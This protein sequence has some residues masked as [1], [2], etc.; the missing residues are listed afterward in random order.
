MFQTNQRVTI[1]II[2]DFCKK[3]ELLMKHKFIIR[4]RYPSPDSRKFNSLNLLSH[5]DCVHLCSLECYKEMAKRN[6]YLLSFRNYTA[7]GKYKDVI[8][9]YEEIEKKKRKKEE[10]RWWRKI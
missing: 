1:F 9:K 7:V 6:E 10:R 8:W 2:C 4:W 5:P 3:E